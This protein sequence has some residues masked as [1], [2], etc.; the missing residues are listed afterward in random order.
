MYQ[1]S[2]RRVAATEDVQ[3]MRTGLSSCRKKEMDPNKSM[4][5]YHVGH[6]NPNVATIHSNIYIYSNMGMICHDI[7]S[8]LIS[9]ADQQL[10]PDTYPDGVLQWRTMSNRPAGGLSSGDSESV[11]I[12]PCWETKVWWFGL[13]WLVVWNGNITTNQWDYG[14][15]NSWVL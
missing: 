4:V 8:I 6:W 12:M 13:Y 3:N 1:P 11:G 14:L 7:P 9:V 15:Y 10:A 2:I 5:C